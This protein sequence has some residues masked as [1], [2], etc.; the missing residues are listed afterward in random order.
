MRRTGVAA[1]DRVVLLMDNRPEYLASMFAAF[2]IGAVIV[3]CNSRATVDELRF[4]LEDCG[5]TL[6]VTDAAHAGVA[7]AATSAAASSAAA[8]F[9]VV[10]DV[11]SDVNPGDPPDAPGAEVPSVA[12]RAPEDV[13]W[14]FYTSGTT[15]TPKGAMLTHAI[16]TFVT[17]GWVGD[18]MPLDE[19]DVT[20]HAAPLSHGA[21]FHALAATARGAH[22]VIPDRTSFDPEAT[23]ELIRTWGVTNTWM[24]PTQIIR[25]S[26]AMTS[27]AS[28]VPTLQH[29]LYGGAPMSPAALQRALEAFGS[30]FTQLYAQGETPMTITVLRP[31]DHRPQLLG[32]VG[33]ARLGVEVSIVD[34]LGR[35]LP[36]GEVGEVVVRGPSVMSGYWQRP[37]ATA[38]TLRGGWLHTGDLGRISAD[39]L[40]TLLDRTKDMIISG[41]SN[42]YAVEVESALSAS[43]A[44]VEV[45]VVGIPDELWGERVEAAVVLGP[46][47]T[48]DRNA[49]DALARSKLAGYKVPRCYHVIDALPRNA[50]GKVLKREL[51]ARLQAEHGSSGA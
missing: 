49:L 33:R 11:D 4:V 47:R 45:G 40:V 10:V 44:V 25:L 6:V 15:G 3:P 38:E 39:G 17:V 37:S 46:G 48:L 34:E 35:E 12:E 20:L 9:G 13:A 14:I 16:L 1:G 8:S 26:E 50:Y 29:V 21:G 42:V 32:T 30:I 2:R 7:A 43:E 24:V 23:L 36:A 28:P 22:Q 5:A 19:H 18:L 27:G 41:G 31:Q 51:R